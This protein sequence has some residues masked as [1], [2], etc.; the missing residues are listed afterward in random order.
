MTVTYSAPTYTFTTTSGSEARLRLPVTTTDA[1]GRVTYS[2]SVDRRGLLMYVGST[3]GGAEIV[4]SVGLLPGDHRIT[5]APGVTTYYIDFVLKDVGVATLSDLTV[6][7]AGILELDTPWAAEDLHSLRKCQSLDVQ[8]WCA[9]GYQTRVLERRGFDSWSL[10]KYQPIDGPFEPTNQTDITIAVDAQTG[11][12]NATASGPLF[13]TYD[14]GGLIRLTH[15]GQYVTENLNTVSETTE[16]IQVTGTLTS[17]NFFYSITG[18]FVG[19][20]ELQRSV[21]NELSWVTVQSFAAPASTSLNDGLD[22]QIVF[23]RL[24]MTAYTSG[25][26]V[27]SLTYSGGTTDG[28]IR[29]VSLSADNAA[30]VDVLT[31]VA[32]TTATVTWNWGSWSDRF[33]WP[34]AVDIVDGRVWFGRDD[35]YWATVADDYESMAVGALAADAIS[36]RSSG[37]G[38]LVRWLKASGAIYLGMSDTEGFI[39]SN[40][41]ADL[42]KPENV[43][44]LLKTAKGSIDA[45]ALP[46]DGGVIFISRSGRRL[47]RMETNG[48][49]VEHFELTRLHEDVCGLPGASEFVELA[50]QSEPSPRVWAVRSDGQLAASLF[51]PSEEINAWQRL[52]YGSAESVCRL[53]GSPEDDIYFIMARTIDGNEV[54]YIEKL[55]PERWESMSEA[56][57]LACAAVYSGASITTITGLD[58]LEGEEVYVWGNGRQ[59]GP[60][61]VESGQIVNDYA[62]T[63]AIVGKQYV[64]KYRGPRLN[65]GAI[66]GAAVTMHKRVIRL[67]LMIYKS[68]AGCVGWGRDFTHVDYL[69]DRTATGP[70]DSPLTE[71]TDDDSFPFQGATE[72]DARICIIFDKAGPGEVLGIVPTLETREQA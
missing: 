20:V 57:R 24:I 55:A 49:T 22:N 16:S 39:G 15:Q 51:A 3:S 30:V 45:D 69:K 52:T 56:W 25:T 71:I 4:D 1:D 8:W 21:G 11:V 42:V 10:R 47:Y 68:A 66:A 2:F 23:Y 5:F 14:V 64:G 9:R 40:T 34:A 18:T 58:H 48:E 60:Y 12:A 72:R 46:H 63:Y 62:V 27:A 33:G 6:L 54:K 19:T 32:S 28:V 70:T 13:K 50:E 36:R 59:S 53:P 37:T 43:R 38:A 29:I 67:G 26:A 44:A 7:P 65:W 61:T 31:P 41:Q 35:R 17:R